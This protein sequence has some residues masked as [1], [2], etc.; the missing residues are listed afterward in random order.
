MDEHS[1]RCPMCGSENSKWKRVVKRLE[2]EK[3]V[4]D[5]NREHGISGRFE[6]E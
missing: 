3:R 6:N 2:Y 1:R 5:F 4:R